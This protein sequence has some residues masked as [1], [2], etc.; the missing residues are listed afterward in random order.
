MKLVIGLGNV[1]SRYAHT[2]HNIGFMVV[3]E[4][5]ERYDAS[6]KLDSKLKA[7]IATL[8]I[9]SEKIILAKP[10][11]MMNLS[12][13]AAQRIMQ[14]YKLALESVWAV[15]D[16][17]DTPFGRMRI[18]HGGSTG[19][20][21]G[22]RSLA[23]HLGE[24]FLRLKVG[25]SLNNRAIEPSEVYVLKPFSD[26]ERQTLP[27]VIARSSEIIA[28]QLSNNIITDETIELL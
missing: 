27:T 18:R 14:K 1:G 3:D 5:A 7:A 17:V 28:A 19:G 22:V 9:D 16:D 15:Y 8:E 13:E 12:G 25:I 6:W 11:T 20:H 24:G 23:E 4:L 10:Q 2:R 26:A 21:Q